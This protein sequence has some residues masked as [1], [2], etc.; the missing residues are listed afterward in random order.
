MKAKPTNSPFKNQGKK[1]LPPDLDRA[2]IREILGH[3]VH[4]EFA[5]WYRQDYKPG[6]FT[7][8]GL[9]YQGPGNSTNIG[10]PVND[11]DKLAQRHDLQYAHAA[12][13]YAKG[14]DTREQYEKRIRNIDGEYVGNN[15]K[16]LTS[17]MNPLEQI[18]SA[19]G[20]LGI[21]TKY[22]GETVFGQQY[23]STD[24]AEAYSLP[25][26]EGKL[27]SKLLGTLKQN[28]SKSSTVQTSGSQMT[29]GNKRVAEE[30]A[31]GASSSKTQ[32]LP[33]PAQAPEAV[34]DVEMA[35][36]TGTGKEQAS[37]GASS[38]GMMVHYIEKPLSIF[39]TR[40]NTYKK[41]HKFMTFGLAPN[42]ISIEADTIGSVVLTSYLAEVPWHIPALYLNQS[43]FD[44]LQPGSRVKSVSIEVIYRG[45]TIQFETASTASGLATLNQI[46]DITVAH[47]LNRSG[48][49]SNVR[50]TAFDT[51]KPMLPTKVTQ[52]IYGPIAGVY[53]GM[54][55]DYYGSNNN[56][57]QFKGD[58]PKHQ[59]GRQTFLY[60]YWANSLRGG[61]TA[62][63][64]NQMFGGW[65]CLTDKIS[66]MDGKTV[67][68]QV[69][70][71][72]TYTP[73][74]APLK[75]PLRMQSHGLPFP[76]PG[77]NLDVQVGGNLVNTRTAQV[78]IPAIA[79]SA[80]VPVRTGAAETSNSINNNS[81]TAPNTQPTFDIYTVIE[82][83]QMGRTGFWGEHDPHIQPSLHV[84]VQPI[85]ALTTSATLLED[86][87][88][89]LWTDTRAY[90]EVVATMVT[91]EHNPTAWPYATQANVPAGD[92]ILWN[93]DTQ[94]PAINTN[95]RSDGAT[96]AGLYSDSL[97]TIAP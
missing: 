4:P 17:S 10:E 28:V 72:S 52:P 51:D 85:P 34:P 45:S 27:A 84:G 92:T 44:L 58:V 15:L 60:N 97:M 42:F 81:S 32:A 7:T 48:Q 78:Q 94:R 26:S 46:N 74:L 75:P 30:P 40:E 80:S 47:G 24:P 77:A 9:K 13:R 18:P 5:E 66:Q 64:N 8:P 86:G 6:G 62:L 71:S 43:E 2:R 93:D 59:I 87:Q 70:A 63:A 50:F 82:K 39:S 73:K 57:V 89:N 21:G 90:W 49:G 20:A 54:V 65:P 68:N 38:D 14:K 91:A 11:A 33:T 79:P 76:L 1:D 69:V 83:S 53:R 96:F 12:F 22:G 55:R 41:S 16:L 23:P 95:P 61:N 3:G 67:V 37:G 29:Q 19:I 36:L 31:E 25:K 35:Q 56:V 88:F